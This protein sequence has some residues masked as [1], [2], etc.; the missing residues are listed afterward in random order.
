MPSA[1]TAQGMGWA[2]LYSAGSVEEM[3]EAGV[4]IS[5]FKYTVFRTH[6]SRYTNAASLG[7]TDPEK[8]TKLL[9]EATDL[10]FFS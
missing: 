5:L 7:S 6:I 8:S 3:C 2:E 1:S 10:G 9:G 4:I